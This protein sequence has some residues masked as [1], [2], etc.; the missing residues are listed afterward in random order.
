VRVEIRL[1]A[2]LERYLPSSAQGDGTILEL[3]ED[4]TVAEVA[5]RLR[6]PDDLPFLVVINGHEAGLDTRLRAGDVV[7]MFPPLAGGAAL[8]RSEAGDTRCRRS[9]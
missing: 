2:T 5:S 3:P 7:V 8:A 1:F 9:G 6:V 4:A